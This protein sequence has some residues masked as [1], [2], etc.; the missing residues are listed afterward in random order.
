MKEDS[1]ILARAIG[2]LE[3]PF[4]KVDNRVV[5]AR[6]GRQGKNRTLSPQSSWAAPTV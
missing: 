2:R 6:L 1:K 5:G 3:L 4:S